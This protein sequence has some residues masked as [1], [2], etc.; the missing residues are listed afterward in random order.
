M[1]VAPSQISTH[2]NLNNQMGNFQ[3]QQN[4][5]YPPQNSF[6]PMPIYNQQ[7]NSSK[8]QNSA[9]PSPSAPPPYSSV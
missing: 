2:Q 5:P 7:E 1:T 3:H 9:T 4:L 6:M 8:F